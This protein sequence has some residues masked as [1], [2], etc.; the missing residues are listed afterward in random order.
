[1]QYCSIVKE[2]NKCSKEERKE[3]REKYAQL[4]GVKEKF[5]GEKNRADRISGGEK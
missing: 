5:W 3:N 4:K 1:M 2:E